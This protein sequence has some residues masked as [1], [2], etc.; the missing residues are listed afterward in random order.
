MPR[1][2]KGICHLQFKAQ[3]KILRCK[4]ENNNSKIEII[5]IDMLSNHFA[6]SGQHFLLGS[7][8]SHL[9]F[10]NVTLTKTSKMEVCLFLKRL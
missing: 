1:I 10:A 8:G 7:L 9:T 4:N 6:S 5:K 2:S 3:Q